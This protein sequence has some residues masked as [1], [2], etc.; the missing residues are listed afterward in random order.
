MPSDSNGANV[1]RPQVPRPST[2]GAAQSGGRDHSISDAR[3]AR[4]SSAHASSS[5]GA[6]HGAGPR[7]ADE[8]S[9]RS[10]SD[11][12]RAATHGASATAT[13][14]RPP[15][16]SAALRSDMADHGSYIPGL[17]GLRALAVGAVILYHVFPGFF[18]GG[19]LGVD[20]FFVI[21]G[22]L[23][24]TLLLRE[25][26]KT[27][28]INLPGFWLRR[29]RRLLPALILLILIVVPAA[30][31]ANT[32]LLVGIRR[33]VLGALTF[34]TNWLEIAH[35]SSYFDQTSPLLFKNFWSLAI[36]EQFYLFWPL[37]FVGV[38]A[39]MKSWRSR[40][41]V[42]GTLAIAS[43]VLMAVLYNA[44]N[45]TR[46]YYGTDTHMFGL[47]LGI[48][49]AFIWADPRSTVL[50]NAGW[51]KHSDLAGFV[52]LGVLLVLMVAMSD[53]GWVAY[54]G[55][56][57]LASLITVVILASIIAPNS[58]LARLGETRVLRWIGTRSY[59]LYLWHWPILI[60]AGVLFPVAHGSMQYNL[61]SITAVV[62]T[63]II[64]ELS[65]RFVETPIR[66]LGF[67]ESWY[68]FVDGV[69]AS[70]APKVVAAGTALALVGTAG[71]M[72]VAPDMTATARQIQEQE[73]LL[74]AEASKTPGQ[75]SATPSGGTSADPSASATATATDAAPSETP[76]ATDDATKPVD[77]GEISKD[78]DTTIP[79][80]SDV[81]AIGDSLIVT[82]KTGLEWVM[83]GMKFLAKSN[84]QWGQVLPIV[85]QGVADGTIGR[86]VVIDLGTNGGIA[87][88][89]FVH[90]TIKAL[91]PDRMI[92]IVNLY[93][94]STF[95]KAANEL[96]ADIAN[97]YPNVRLVDWASLAASDPDLL[98]VDGTHPT[99]AGANAFGQ[100]VK[101]AITAFAT[102]LSKA[103]GVDPGK[104]WN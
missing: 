14:T 26:R 68:R 87:D 50:G 56:M 6:R 21:S 57:F 64:C 63:G 97:Q 1:P 69:R 80:A 84:R 44:S 81:T 93:S 51:R 13:A 2:H 15:Q 65:Y 70:I 92:L 17:D 4:S 100:M 9:S 11:A 79:N 96:L 8:R 7:P 20:V 39:G 45:T 32:D 99:I 102:D 94:G 47:A 27:G 31:A 48:C 53:S 24:T 103:K 75:P 73:A 18:R 88:E 54:I 66:K 36:E 90:D 22:F 78:L 25:L 41:G 71:A 101:D 49:L 29:A 76:S 43:A 89:A 77:V 61:R 86:V 58:L 98:Q 30:W 40:L 34:S 3:A 91:G 12:G 5:G 72:I 38:I 74:D 62:V 85:Q 59:G 67:K 42:S 23:I 16:R 60:L 52:A 10:R 35:G 33:Q 55:G 46:L 19:F 95:I 28:R 37:I 104:G 83:P 82:T